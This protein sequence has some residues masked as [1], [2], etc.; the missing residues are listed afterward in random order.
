MQRPSLLDELRRRPGWRG[1]VKE[2]VFNYGCERA[3]VPGV[4]GDKSGHLRVL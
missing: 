1:S 4:L 2:K 3:R